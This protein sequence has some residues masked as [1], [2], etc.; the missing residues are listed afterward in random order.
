MLKSSNFQRVRLALGLTRKSGVVAFGVV[1]FELLFGRVALSTSL[2]VD[3]CN[4]AKWAHECILKGKVDQIIDKRIE[5]QIYPKCLK[6]FVQIAHRCLHS[7]SK[8]R[9]TMAEMVVALELTLALQVKFD[10]H[11]KPQGILAFTKW[12]KCLFFSPE[13]HSGPLGFP[14]QENHIINSRDLE[15]L[16]IFTS[17]VHGSQTNQLQR[18]SRHNLLSQEP[19]YDVKCQ[20]QY[21]V[22]KVTL[23]V[24]LNESVN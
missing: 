19:V 24:H 10:N 8:K 11:V 4:L 9:P 14:F 23:V 1:L 6:V 3:E 2:D 13:L 7:E 16:L 17:Q 5:T 15:N 12:M 18:L 21:L 22:L 20:Q